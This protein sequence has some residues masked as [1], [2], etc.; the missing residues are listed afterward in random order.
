VRRDGGGVICSRVGEVTFTLAY[1]NLTSRARELTLQYARNRGNPQTHARPLPLALPLP[2]PHL[3]HS[4]Y[5]AKKDGNLLHVATVTASA[6][7]VGSRREGGRSWG[8]RGRRR[9]RSDMFRGRDAWE[10][11]VIVASARPRGEGLV[12]RWPDSSSERTVLSIIGTVFPSF[13]AS[14][15]SFLILGF[16]G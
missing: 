6:L 11:D 10:G 3:Q 7:L 2:R 15:F 9:R 16:R 1:L 8:E 5:K 12:L 14:L 13:P 4:K